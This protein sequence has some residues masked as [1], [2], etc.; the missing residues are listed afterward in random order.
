MSDENESEPADEEEFEVEN[1]LDKRKRQGGTEY[2]IKWLG[3]DDTH[4]TWEPEENLGFG[5]Q[6]VI[7]EF[8]A[9]FERNK[10]SRKKRK[11]KKSDLE[12]KSGIRIDTRVV[13]IRKG[14]YDLEYRQNM[15][16]TMP[17]QSLIDEF[18]GMDLT[19][20]PD[21]NLPFENHWQ[22][23]EKSGFN[24]GFTP[25]EIHESF[26]DADGQVFFVVE[27]VGSKIIDFVKREECVA[28]CPKV[29]CAFYQRLFEDVIEDWKGVYLFDDILPRKTAK[30]GELEQP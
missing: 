20:I 9:N 6:E 26:R 21:P 7:G 14:Q 8:E 24:R 25:K 29:V 15:S 1:I 11:R 19:S 27:W 2:L 13:D 5:L 23:E 28:K 18:S 12:F 30:P 16:K 22:S 4:N 10:T 17:R 3:Y